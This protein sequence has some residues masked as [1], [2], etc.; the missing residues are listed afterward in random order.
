MV[1]WA[2]AGDFQG[3]LTYGIGIAWPN[4]QFAVRT[5]EVE[6]ITAQGQHLYIV[7]L[8]IDATS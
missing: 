4:P 8:D 5:I 1:S 3:V 7:A 6:R 2:Q